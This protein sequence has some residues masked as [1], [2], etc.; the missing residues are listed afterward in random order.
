MKVVDVVVGEHNQN[1]NEYEFVGHYNGYDYY[2]FTEAQISLDENDWTMHPGYD[3]TLS[4]EDQTFTNDVC[5]L[6]HKAGG[7]L[8]KGR[9]A[10]LPQKG[11]QVTSK[12]NPSVIN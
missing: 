1:L 9:H 12:R 10:C 5:I 4:D 6:K 11:I 8:Q 3:H 7:L 2:D